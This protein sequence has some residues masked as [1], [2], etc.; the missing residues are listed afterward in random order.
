MVGSCRGA[1]IFGVWVSVLGHCRDT[2]WLG[3]ARIL[4]GWPLQFYLAV[5]RLGTA[6]MLGGWACT[7]TWRLVTAGT[8]GGWAVQGYS[9]VGHWLGTSDIRGGWAL[10]TYVVVGHCRDT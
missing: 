5:G 7:D 1:G 4:G 9:V 2:W 6:R 10:Q 8:H 3:T